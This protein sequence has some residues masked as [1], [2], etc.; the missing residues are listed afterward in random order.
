MKP[1]GAA[2][3]TCPGRDA[4]CVPPEPAR[5]RT[6]LVV[7]GEGPGRHELREGRP[8]IGQSG[9]MMV[10][11]AKVLGLARSNVHWTNAILCD[12]KPHLMAKAAKACRARLQAELAEVR[13][14]LVMPVGAWGL[15]GALGTSA[16]PQI[17]KWRGSINPHTFDSVGHGTASCGGVGLGRVSS[18]V[19][20]T[21]HPAFIMRA[22]QWRRIFEVDVERVARIAETGFTPPEL[23]PGRRTV[24]ARTRE[25]LTAALADL[26]PGAPAS[27]DVETVGLG[28]TET[29]LVC[30]GIS[31]G[32]LTI[33]VPWSTASNG[34]EPWW[35]AVGGPDVAR[36]VSA[37]LASRVT[38]T[39]NGPAF[40]HIVAARYG[41]RIAAWDDT[42]LA[43]HAIAGHLPKNLA[44]V[45]TTAG[46]GAIAVTA[47]KQQ[48]SRS[49]S[50]DELHIYNGRDCLYTILAWYELRKEVTQCAA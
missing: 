30:F 37:A 46:D 21:V 4:K 41:I 25:S 32:V 49:G 47:W 8:F 31:D 22:P 26:I 40:D 20:P 36:E 9:K 16:K 35:G 38:V 2:C 42:L 50:L 7:V 28:P 17:L 34:L 1:A 23:Q 33:V 10:R 11:A 39:H 27:F 13:A 3:A 19:A 43:T 44:H 15:Q 24:I 29:A 45:V 18:L 6:H 48:E 14:P 5:G 12:V